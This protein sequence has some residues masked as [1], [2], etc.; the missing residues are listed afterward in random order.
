[1]LI[2]IVYC[3]T[4]GSVKPK[5]QC[6]VAPFVL[7]FGF[8]SFCCIWWRFLFALQINIQSSFSCALTSWCW[9]QITEYFQRPWVSHSP[10][11]LWARERGKNA[12]RRATKMK[13]KFS[14]EKAHF[15]AFS[16]E[17][18]LEMFG[19]VQ[20]K[21]FKNQ[22]KFLHAFPIHI[23]SV[24]IKIEFGWEFSNSQL[25]KSEVNEREKQEKRMK[26]TKNLLKDM[27]RMKK[28]SNIFN[29]NCHWSGR[30]YEKRKKE[31]RPKNEGEGEKL[32]VFELQWANGCPKHQMKE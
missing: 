25:E 28:W 10:L 29:T 3:E 19:L 15:I 12:F 16:F 22:L 17:P 9:L 7:N 21:L 31:R 13:M 14:D 11:P 5:F 18:S 26:W 1:M 30:K 24:R 27:N 20:S 6:S 23:K 2:R 4:N 8:I 32:Q